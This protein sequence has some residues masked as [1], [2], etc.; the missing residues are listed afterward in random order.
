MIYPSVD[1]LYMKT[2]EMLFFTYYDIA[3]LEGINI[4]RLGDSVDYKKLTINQLPAYYY[5]ASKRV[6]GSDIVIVDEGNNLVFII[7]AILPEDVLVSIAES[8]VCSETEW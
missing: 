1:L 7:C 5:P 2:D 8:I 4:D 6:L 3:E